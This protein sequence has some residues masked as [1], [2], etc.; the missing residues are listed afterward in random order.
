MEICPNRHSPTGFLEEANFNCAEKNV[1]GITKKAVAILL[2]LG[3]KPKYPLPVDDSVISQPVEQWLEN[4]FRENNAYGAGSSIGHCIGVRVQGLLAQGRDP[5]QDSVVAT[6]LQWLHENQDE[7]TGF[8]RHKGDLK[9][10]MNGLLKMRLG[11]FQLTGT[12]IPRPEKVVQTILSLQGDDGRFARSC[13]DFNGTTLITDL[14]RGT[15]QYHEAILS[16]CQQILPAFAAK[17]RSDGGFCWE[18]QDT[19]EPNLNATQ[20]N[21]KGLADMREFLIWLSERSY[22]GTIE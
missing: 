3:A 13:G 16:A 18:P 14:G 9:M 17:Q 15:P 12:A 1:I 6:V 2:N 21:A 20:V 5:K 10:G 7:E 19:E 11:V 22:K 4:T 8:F